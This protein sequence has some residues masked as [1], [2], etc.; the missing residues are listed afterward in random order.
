MSLRI[1]RRQLLGS[2]IRA[3]IG[4]ALW[5][6]LKPGAVPAFAFTAPKTLSNDARFQTAFGRLDEFIA[7][8]LRDIG[9]LQW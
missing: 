7:A 2:G 3:G 5:K 1:T 8:H 4:L 9:A 6:E